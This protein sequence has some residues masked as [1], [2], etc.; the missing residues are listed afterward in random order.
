MR[1]PARKPPTSRIVG[2]R[3]EGTIVDLPRVE[4]ILRRAEKERV[5][6]QYVAKTY[7]APEERVDCVW[8]N[9]PPGR[10]LRKVRDAV[11]ALMQNVRVEPRR[12]A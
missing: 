1:Q 10:E 5:V 2:Y 6:T 9:G 11:H 7:G 3:Y 12:R 8:F 4:A